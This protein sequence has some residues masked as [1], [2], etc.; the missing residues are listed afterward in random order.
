MGVSN[1]RTLYIKEQKY[2]KMYLKKAL[3]HHKS[4]QALLNLTNIPHTQCGHSC[5]GSSSKTKCY[6]IRFILDFKIVYIYQK[7]LFSSTVLYGLL[8]GLTFFLIFIQAFH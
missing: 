5:I 3:K 6:S 4:L 2:L 1:V 8:K 7:K